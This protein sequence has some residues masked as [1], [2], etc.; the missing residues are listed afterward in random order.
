MGRKSGKAR[1]SAKALVQAKSICARATGAPTSDA[2]ILE[3]ARVLFKLRSGL[4]I[5]QEEGTVTDALA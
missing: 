2:E 4:E 5:E 1:S 3:T